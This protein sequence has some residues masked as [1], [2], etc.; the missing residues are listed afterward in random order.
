M[1]MKIAALFTLLVLAGCD[2]TSETTQANNAPTKHKSE[3]ALAEGSTLMLNA[4]HLKSY[5]KPNSAGNLQMHE[6]S[7]PAVDKMA[8]NDVYMHMKTAGYTRKVISSG[9]APYKVQYYKK[10]TPVVGGIYTMVNRNDKTETI[11]TIYW[12]GK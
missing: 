11:A 3:L 12:Q 1:K 8:E 4:A 6:F 7:Y 9:N 5:A 10:D 2:Q